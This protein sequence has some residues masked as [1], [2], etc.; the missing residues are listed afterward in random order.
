MGVSSFFA[1]CVCRD[2]NLKGREGFAPPAVVTRQSEREGGMER[3]F[4]L[5]L[6][7]SSLGADE[8]KRGNGM[9]GYIDLR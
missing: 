8:R 6:S 2:S 5:S 4:S 7:A 9:D 3:P 1:S